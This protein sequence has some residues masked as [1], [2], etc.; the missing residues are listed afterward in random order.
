[1]SEDRIDRMKQQLADLQRRIEAAEA[2]QKEQDRKRDNK[3]KYLLGAML[4][5]WMEHDPQMEKTVMERMDNFLE[6][7]NDRKWFGLPPR[8]EEPPTPE[9]KEKS[10]EVKK[11]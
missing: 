7:K 6:R 4:Q 3:Q 2:K 11:Q 8:D 10:E 1:M 5:T 9:K